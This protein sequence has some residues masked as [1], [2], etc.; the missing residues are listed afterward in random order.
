MADI[1]QSLPERENGTFKAEARE[2][3]L[4]DIW[5]VLYRRRGWAL[6]TFAA[7]AAATVA[8]VWSVTP[9]YEAHSQLLIGDKPNIV[10]FQG[11][12]N[13]SNDQQGDLETQYRLLRSRSL[14]R[15]VI[16]ELK[17]WDAN[18]MNPNGQFAV[19]DSF[20][21]W[22]GTRAKSAPAA[23][24]S[25][26]THSES[27]VIDRMLANLNV[28]PIRDTRIIEIRYESSDP[29]LA[30][31]VVNTL[32]STYITLNLEVR[33][34]ASKEAAEWLNQQ[35]AEQRRK[36]E[37]SELALQKYRERENSLSLEAGQNIVV[38]RLNALNSSVTQ[39]KTDLITVEALYR[40]LAASQVD[41]AA[42]DT[43]PSI[44]SNSIVQ[45]IRTRLGSLQRERIELSRS[46]GT[47]HP[48]MVR[49]DTAIKTAELELE[50][51]V[52]KTVESVRQDY[53]TAVA[54]ERELTAALNTQKASA[55]AL[56]KQGIEYRRAAQGS[57]KQPPDLSEPAS[58]N[59]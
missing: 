3:H 36:V 4:Q 10:T 56:N 19:L 28:V 40:Q 38:Q 1:Q 41:R 12:D 45:E 42:L 53:L 34:H 26:E 52:A 5:S 22:S 21:F 2:W 31:R 37:I 46:L 15:R 55:L 24:D 14:A 25:K 58:A 13:T 20:A 23:S 39:A 32:T 43:F 16:D 44:R 33:S 54:R 57:R 18:D 27:V 7:V 50:T 6:A 49:L 29:E 9:I 59:Q 51:A 17:L 35:L 47:K 48:E 11:T 8:Y 30:A